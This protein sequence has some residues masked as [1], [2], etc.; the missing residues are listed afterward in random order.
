[1]R[2]VDVCPSENSGRDLGLEISPAP[3]PR[4]AIPPSRERRDPLTFCGWAA[5]PNQIRATLLWNQPKNVMDDGPT[6]VSLGTLAVRAR[7]RRTDKRRV[8]QDCLV[9]FRCQR[10]VVAYP[11]ST[12]SCS[13]TGGRK[14]TLYITR[15]HR[16]SQ[17]LVWL[18]GGSFAGVERRARVRAFL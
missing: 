16:T 8:C 1:M 17:S 14:V 15:I 7:Y 2:K 4:G 10:V 3:R 9:G 18:L 13:I 11:E 6:S 12:L 5:F